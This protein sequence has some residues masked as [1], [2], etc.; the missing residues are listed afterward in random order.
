M[1]KQKTLL[2]FP[3]LFN[4]DQPYG[5]TPILTAYL[6]K[7]GFSVTQKDLNAEFWHH[8]LQKNE[9]KKIYKNAN[10]LNPQKIKDPQTL[11]LKKFISSFSE[12]QFIKAVQEKKLS[13]K[14]H[15]S[16]QI[17][18]SIAN[19]FSDFSY[20]LFSK[21]FLRKTPWEN[22]LYYNCFIES[23]FA[24]LAISSKKL[25][26][27]THSNKNPYYKF[28][29]KTVS[30]ELNKSTPN[31]IGISVTTIGQLAPSLALCRVIKESD[32]KTHITLGGSYITH[33]HSTL[34]QKPELFKLFDSAILFE[35][36]KPLEKLVK[37]L[38]EKQPLS[39]VPN[40]LFL[41]N[42][43]VIL[44]NF[45][46]PVDLN[47]LSS[48]TTDGLDL[49]KYS[50]QK[51]M[52]LQT[53][54]GCYWGKCR[55][56]S[57]C[58]LEKNLK[59]RN[60]SKVIQDMQSLYSQGLTKFLLVD[61]AITPSRFKQL[62]QAILDSPL[63][64]KITWGCFGRFNESF[65]EETIKLM[66]L[67]GCKYIDWGL[68]SGSPE[69]LKYINKGIDLNTASK[70]LKLCAKHGIMNRANIIFGFPN[71]TWRN[72]KQTISFIESNKSFLED[73]SP[74]YF[75]LEKNTEFF[76]SSKKFKI[77]PIQNPE[78]D[79]ACN[80]SHNKKLTHAQIKKAMKIFTELNHK[81][82]NQSPNNSVTNKNNP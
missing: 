14:P 52:S 2:I 54:R 25:L 70:I 27:F 50:L 24:P 29:K 31:L 34:Q 42:E 76:N 56:C 15:T 17:F 8:F 71:E 28:F 19:L 35:G 43:K 18:F 39:R 53:S 6:R 80:F 12:E 57:Y 22:P 67:S 36:E 63:R 26:S 60:I 59:L 20:E 55:F 68:E 51:V 46:E 38:G 47:E 69:T 3:P 9:I 48:P 30:K 65:N 40:L 49:E 23:S 75:S 32:K 66:S 7:K 37:T 16:Q 62:S 10:S 33:I 41:E 74:E 72:I 5:A 1:T 79:L 45:S 21:K 4:L 64:N 77:K 11:R 81:I 82:K 78:N 58:F 73:I 13:K 44:N 61:T